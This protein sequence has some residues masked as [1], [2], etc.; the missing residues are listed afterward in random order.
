M[1]AEFF[2]RALKIL[3]DLTT[4][5]I[6]KHLTECGIE[7]NRRITSYSEDEV[8]FVG[9]VDQQDAVEVNFDSCI[10]QDDIFEAA[11]NDELYALAA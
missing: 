10:S 8:D 3:Q 2:E 7:F 6:E 11:A 4:E 5:D 9:T 1:N